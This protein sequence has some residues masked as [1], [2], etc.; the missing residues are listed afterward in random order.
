MPDFVVVGFIE[1]VHG[2][3]GTVKVKPTTDHPPRFKQLRTVFIETPDGEINEF[4]I[5]RVS[6]QGEVVYLCFENIETREQALAL[7]G[8]AIKIK[9]EDCLPLKEGHYYHFELLG[10]A[11]KTTNGEEVGWVEEVW[12]LPAN[13]V[14]VV[15]KEAREF[16][17]PA[18]KDVI[19]RIDV[20]KGEIIIEPMEGLLE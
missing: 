12:D 3:K 5:S 17:I 6:V 4:E 8:S 2:I 14:L 11:V 1:K 13:A 16:L 18:I 9:R 19:R 10:L 7:K 20:E 15:K